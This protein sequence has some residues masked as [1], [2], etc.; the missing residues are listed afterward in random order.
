MTGSCS[1]R[2]IFAV[3]RWSGPSTSI[4]KPVSILWQ[5]VWYCNEEL[6]PQLRDA[7]QFFGVTGGLLTY[8]VGPYKQESGE[9]GFRHRMGLLGEIEFQT[10]EASRQ[11][12]TNVFRPRTEA[13][14]MGQ[15][16]LIDWL[17]MPAS[18]PQALR[19]LLAGSS[20]SYP[21]D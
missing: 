19:F 2:S 7:A 15:P 17:A 14:L 9:L 4:P 11:F 21:I 8:Q 3:S 13:V 18:S 5:C 20:T 12:F 1:G 10:P 16:A 6:K